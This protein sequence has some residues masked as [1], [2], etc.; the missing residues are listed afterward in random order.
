MATEPQA[1]AVERPTT[2]LDEVVFNMSLTGMSQRAIAAE[3]GISKTQVHRI[4]T[5]MHDSYIPERYAD[6]TRNLA[7]ELAILDVLTRGNLAAA[8]AGS[9]NAADIVHNAHIRR[10]KLLGLEN[11][12]KLEVTLKTAQDVEIERLMQMMTGGNA[13]TEAMR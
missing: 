6:M 7:H 5:R 1:A 10:C 8:A 9:K 12:M 2:E 11:A 13:T 4:V 3:V